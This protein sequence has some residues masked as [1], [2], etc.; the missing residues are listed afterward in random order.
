M[1]VAVKSAVPPASDAPRR[2]P[3]QPA[4]ASQDP[5]VRAARFVADSAIRSVAAL[6]EPSAAVQSAL[7]QSFAAADQSLGGEHT[8]ALQVTGSRVQINFNRHSFLLL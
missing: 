1:N 2:E 8:P 6:Q 4:V 7:R 5:P 3:A